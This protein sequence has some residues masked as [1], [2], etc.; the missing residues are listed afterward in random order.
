VKSS[1]IN[2]YDNPVAERNV[3]WLLKKSDVLVPVLMSMSTRQS[4]SLNDLLRICHRQTFVVK[5]AKAV[6]DKASMDPM[7]R[8]DPEFAQRSH[9]Q[10]VPFMHDRAWGNDP[11]RILSSTTPPRPVPRG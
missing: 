7:P 2:P 9:W 4:Q 6:I 5:F 8:Y 3:V 11:P 10:I 1:P